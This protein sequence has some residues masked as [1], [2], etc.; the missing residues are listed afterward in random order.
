MKQFLSVIAAVIFIF[1]SCKTDVDITGEWKETPIIY[2]LINP[3]STN[4]YFK[5]YRSY[6]DE[7]TNALD[8]TQ[9]ADS[10]YYSDSIIVYLEKVSTGQKFYLSKID[11]NSI[12]IT[13]DS[14]LF[15][16]SPNVLYVVNHTIDVQSLYRFG[17][18]NPATG[19][20][21]TSEA[22][23]VGDFQINFPTPSFN[24]NLNATSPYNIQWRSA[25]NSR[26][27]DVSVV[28][29]YTEWHVSNPSNVS[30]KFIE[31]KLASGIVS[32]TSNGGEQLS[33]RFN[34]QDFYLTLKN[35]L[36]VNN[37]I[38][39]LANAQPFEIKFYTGGEELYNFIRV[40]RAQSG[41]SS[42]QVLTEYTN[43][44]GGLGVFSSRKIKVRDELGITTV[45]LDSLSCGSITRELNFVNFPCN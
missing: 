9:N 42:L 32:N 14:G 20:T 38:R 8:F 39:R 15:V 45:S 35:S 23:M 18:E 29:R 7:K 28:F 41:I 11:G 13:M 34:P 31:L 4:H 44:E 40:N 3:D 36:E 24:I 5:I 16:N 1:S 22:R 27:N 10:I 26:T 17:F 21:A 25:P 2:G 30:N 33:I 19:K 12:G 37:E 6:L 43:I